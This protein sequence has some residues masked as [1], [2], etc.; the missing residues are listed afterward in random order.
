M[1]TTTDQRRPMAADMTV[2]P[3]GSS[4]TPAGPPAPPVRTLVA[5]FAAAL[6][7]SNTVLLGQVLR[8]L[9]TERCQTL[10]TQTLAIEGAGG[11]QTK[12]GTRRCTPGGVFFQLVRAACTPR[13]RARLF[14]PPRQPGRAA[15]PVP[16]PTP[17]TW[18]QIADLAQTCDT[19]PVGEATMK[20][21]LVGRP[22][23]I[24]VRGQVAVMLMQ[25]APAPA[26]A[27]GLPAPTGAPLRWTVLVGLRQ[28]NRVKEALAA[29]EEDKLVIEGYPTMQGDRH[30]L[31]AQ[32]CVSVLQQRA[33]KQA[34]QQ[35]AQT[36]PAA[37][38]AST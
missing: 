12:D 3:S 28:W 35:A 16:N 34:Q 13:E 8:V 26:L 22:A 20:L 4:P 30:V 11:M 36:P 17:L 6:Q 9:G 25:G 29:H 7:E 10:L 24:E 15:P 18:A 23:H 19:H 27:M 2:N 21:T 38:D 14:P 31:L 1:S 5:D 33:R 37:E 32:S